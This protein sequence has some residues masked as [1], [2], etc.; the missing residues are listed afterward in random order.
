MNEHGEDPDMPERG[1]DP[2]PGGQPGAGTEPQPSM[3][4][5]RYR[6]LL[7]LLPASYRLAWEEDMVATFLASVHSDDPEEAELVAELGRPGL[8]EVASVLALAVRLRIP[9]LRLELGGRAQ[10]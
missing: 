7:R 5:Q 2:E 6:S 1:V 4:E 8:A 9:G 10:S 3:I